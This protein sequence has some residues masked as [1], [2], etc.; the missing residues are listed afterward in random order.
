M[1]ALHFHALV[2]EIT[3]R[4]NARCAMCYQAAGPRGS[5]LRGDGNLPLDVV[6]RVIDE[7]AQ[8]PNLDSRLHI[9]GGE[10]FLRYDDTVAIFK[11]GKQR[12]FLNIGSTTNGFWAVNRGVAERRCRELVE[13]GV[14]YFEISLDYWHLPYVSPDRLRSLFHACR[15]TGIKIVLRTLATRAHHADEIFTTFSDADLLDV[16]IANGRVFPV[17]RA[18]TEVPADDIYFD[19]EVTGC[20]EN[21]LSLTVGPNGNVYPCCAGADMTESM[22]AGNVYRDSLSEAVFKMR[23]DRTIR[24]VIHSGTGSLIPLIKELGYGE[25]LKDRYANI[26]H[27]CWDVFKD[28]ELANALRGHFAEQEFAELA[29]ILLNGVSVEESPS[30]P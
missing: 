24:Q 16:F 6:C 11:H 23:T 1:K 2:L 27:L 30:V 22:A 29:Q 15:Q 8:L 3:D 28:N 10:A 9:S 26:C 14:T 19:K 5:D 25:R 7:A 4:C 12:G 20:C 17:G 21:L 18:A 13:A